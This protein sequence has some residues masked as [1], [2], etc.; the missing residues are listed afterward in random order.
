MKVLMI[1]FM[2]AV[3]LT[4]LFLAAVKNTFASI[5]KVEAE[6]E[7]EMREHHERMESLK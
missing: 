4:S 5:D 6:K 3:A 2:S 1:I 7:Q